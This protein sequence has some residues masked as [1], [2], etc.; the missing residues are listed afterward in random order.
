LST[1]VN[2]PVFF[3]GFSIFTDVRVA[4]FIATGFVP[5]RFAF[6]KSNIPGLID[7][8]NGRLHS[9]PFRLI[10]I[11]R[12]I[13]SGSV[14]A[15]LLQES[16]LFLASILVLIELIDFILSALRWK[17]RVR[18]CCMLLVSSRD[19]LVGTTP[20][21]RSYQWDLHSGDLVQDQSYH[22]SS[23]DRETNAQ[24]S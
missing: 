2:T 12:L 14:Q 4:M 1:Q 23:Q 5:A 3:H 20:Q 6:I 15:T 10:T 21:G 17:T 24:M 9:S 13:C 22:Y 8:C 16:Y 11:C 18:S 7:P 19:V